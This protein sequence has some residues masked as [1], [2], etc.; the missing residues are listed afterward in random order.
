M[1]NWE[2]CYKTGFGWVKSL[3]YLR[4]YNHANRVYD[5]HVD[6][7]DCTLFKRKKDA[8]VISITNQLHYQGVEEAVVFS[9]FFELQ[10]PW[11]PTSRCTSFRVQIMIIGKKAFLVMLWKH[12]GTKV[13]RTLPSMT[14]K[15]STVMWFKFNPIFL[16]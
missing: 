5:A 10:E 6:W 4:A 14:S 3:C 15:L 8:R 13:P 16:Q 1:C 7:H 12:L 11:K 2:F 9:F